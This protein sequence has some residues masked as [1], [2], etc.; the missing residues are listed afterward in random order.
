MLLPEV[1]K[2]FEL[3]LENWWKQKQSQI[4]TAMPGTVNKWNYPDKGKNTVSAV[5]AMMGY[6]MG[7]DGKYTAEPMPEHLDVPVYYMGGGGFHFTHPLKQGDEGL[8]IYASRC[9]DGAWQ[10][11]GHPKPAHQPDY[12]IPTAAGLRMHDL[13]DAMFIPFRFSDKH[14]LENISQTDAQLRSDDGTSYISMKP[15]GG[16]FD[17]VTPD[18]YM[19]LDGS[20]NLKLKGNVTAFNDGDK[21]DMRHLHTDAGGSG[22]SGPPKPNT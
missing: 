2:D 21:I 6:K 15:N 4:W 3:F 7:S 1:G 5:P 20:G 10:N 19:K 12:A 9:I 14:K 16:G 17:M 11:G 8:L 13:S 18:G 22:D